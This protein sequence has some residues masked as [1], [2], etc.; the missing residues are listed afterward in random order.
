METIWSWKLSFNYTAKALLTKLKFG[1]LLKKVTWVIEIED[2]TFFKEKS[3][4]ISI[5]ELCNL[6]KIMLKMIQKKNL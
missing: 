3:N 6:N 4:E 5:F 2:I 1:H